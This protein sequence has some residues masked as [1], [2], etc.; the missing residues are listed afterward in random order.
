MDT[1]FMNL[2]NSKTTDPHRILLNVSDEINLDM[3]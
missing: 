3:W 1:T 2:G